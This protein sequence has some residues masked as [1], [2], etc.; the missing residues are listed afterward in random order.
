MLPLRPQQQK[1]IV[2]FEFFFGRS[3][4]VATLKPRRLNKKRCL[5]TKKKALSAR[6]AEVIRLRQVIARSQSLS[7]ASDRQIAAK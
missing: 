4:R 6:Y 5:K 1:F 3:A 7:K 2:V